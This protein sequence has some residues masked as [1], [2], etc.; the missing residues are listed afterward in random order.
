M[1]SYM[2]AKTLLF[3]SLVSCISC[4]TKS[5]GEKVPKF[6]TITFS[7]DIFNL[8]ENTR[9][10]VEF[11][12]ENTFVKVVKKANKFEIKAKKKTTFFGKK[13]LSL[14]VVKDSVHFKNLVRLHIFQKT[15][16]SLDLIG[17]KSKFVTANTPAENHDMFLQEGFDKRIIES[18]SNRSGIIF[19]YTGKCK[20]RYNPLKKEEEEIEKLVNFRIKEWIAGRLKTECLIDVYKY[21]KFEAIRD[22]LN[23]EELQNLSFAYYL[24]PVSNLIEPFILLNTQTTKD[25]LIS[26]LNLDSKVDTFKDLT[27][28]DID[29]IKTTIENHKLSRFSPP[30]AYE[31]VSFKIKTLENCYSSINFNQFFKE[32]NGEFVLKCTKSIIDIPIIIPAGLSI[33]FNAG[34]T[35]DIR[36]GGFIMSFSPVIMSGEKDNL[37]QITSSD[38]LGKGFHVINARLP[39]KL[40]YVRFDG[41]SSLN[42]K[43]WKLP[44]AVTFY[45]SPV[46]IDFCLFSN[47]HCEDAINIFR[48]SPYSL[49]NSTISNS[50]SDAFDADFSDG[51]ISNCKFINIGND[52]IDVSG[53]NTFIKNSSFINVADKAISAGESSKITIDSVSID[54]V[55]LAITAKD[56][57]RIQISNS[58]ITNAAVIYCAFQKKSEF[59]PSSISA[60]NVSYSNFKEQDLIEEGSKLKVD[61]KKIHNYRTNVRKYLYG[62]EYGK[63][64]IR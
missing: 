16:K 43:H 5:G 40:N 55:S 24:N 39:S 31:A 50:F 13:K 22:L 36:K 53:S 29:Q 19:T 41:L 6:D 26:R 8:K 57:S 61:G 2:R 54:S 21:G 7:H 46:E 27:S 48:S 64:T 59:G 18:N 9:V 28:K 42:Y 15:L 1:S 14:F 25:E 47:N 11:K 12:D 44:S 60:K 20:I 30:V 52:G 35:I 4:G 62:N 45:E 3:L 38:M 51:I 10:G 23:I 56:L 17:L 34:D 37:I 49:T 32:I 58:T 33:R 63:K